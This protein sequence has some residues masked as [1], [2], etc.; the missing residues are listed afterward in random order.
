V[1]GLWLFAAAGAGEAGPT[2]AGNLLCLGSTLVF[3]L[4][5]LASQRAASSVPHHVYLPLV[6]LWGGLL[7][8]PLAVLRG[9]LAT[10]PWGDLQAWLWLLALAAVPTIVGHGSLMYGVRFYSP[11]VVSFFTL[12]EPPGATLFA[13]LLLA[14]APRLAEMPS[15][16]LFLGSTALFLWQNRALGPRGAAPRAPEPQP[17]RPEGR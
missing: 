3:V 6:Y 2:L 14:E 10:A 11:L 9:A 7:T 16:V 4:Y 13:Y 8:L 15:Y 1:G 5:L 12:F 17:P